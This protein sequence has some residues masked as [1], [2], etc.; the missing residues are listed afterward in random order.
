MSEL[1]ETIENEIYWSLRKE[2]RL[3]GKF[4]FGCRIVSLYEL[5]R[6]DEF[7]GFNPFLFIPGMAAMV[8]MIGVATIVGQEDADYFYGG[9]FEK[10]MVNLD[11]KSYSD[12]DA[13][14]NI[15]K[16]KQKIKDNYDFARAHDPKSKRWHAPLLHFKWTSYWLYRA[17]C[18]DF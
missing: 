3:H 12:A 2:F 6:Q 13:I 11:M 4:S 18:G 17:I 8:G 10:E 16:L 9:L 1:K 15:E 7:I 5:N 14:V